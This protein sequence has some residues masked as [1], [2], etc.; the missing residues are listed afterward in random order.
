M[1]ITFPARLACLN[2]GAGRR[3]GQET[4][5]HAFRVISWKRNIKVSQ[6]CLLVIDSVG[7]MPYK[8]NTLQ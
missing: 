7:V 6:N 4:G 8:S 3:S 1:K 2:P 5:I